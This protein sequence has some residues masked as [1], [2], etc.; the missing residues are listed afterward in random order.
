[1]AF[2]PTGNRLYLLN[3]RPPTLQILDTS[4]SPTGV[5]LNR[6]A[7]AV[8]ICRQASTVTVVDS[9]DGERVYLTCFQDGQIYVVDPRG[10]GRVEEVITVGQ[11]PYSVAA[12]PGGQRLYVTTSSRTPSL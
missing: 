7:G 8:D 1:M 4:L 3:R 12:T 6:L 9:G 11:G 5:P 2:S 10:T